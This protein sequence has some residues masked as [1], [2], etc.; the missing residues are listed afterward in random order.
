M[1]IPSGPFAEVPVTQPETVSGFRDRSSLLTLF[2]VV[3]IILGALCALFIPLIFLG[4]VMSRNSG[5]PSAPFSTHLAGVAVYFGLAVAFIWLGIGSIQARRWAHALTLIFSWIGLISGIF[6]I[7][8]VTAILPVSFLAG[9]HAA[10]SQNPQA[11]SVS[12]GVMA[13]I[14]TFMIVI[15]AIFLIG[16]PTAFVIFY[17]RRNVRETVRRRDP[18]E[19]W[20]DRCPLP[21]L[22]ACVLFTSGAAYSLLIGITTPLFPFFGRYI[23]GV[24]AGVILLILAAFDFFLAWAV[25]HLRLFAWWLAICAIVLR[26]ISY[27]ITFRRGD[28]LQAYSRLGWSS[29][30]VQM[31]RQNPLVRSGAVQWWGLGISLAFLGYLIYLKKYFKSAQSQETTSA[32]NATIPL[33]MP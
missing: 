29:S 23:T 17:S 25:F 8:I 32:D 2:G 30:R 31:L 12:T 7:I 16:I 18:I 11:A 24:S 21:V 26:I 27:A 19:R 5:A 1:D 3:Q 13:V 10:T 15:F 4:I 14:L 33:A 6:I 22:A 9:M 28:I 20:T